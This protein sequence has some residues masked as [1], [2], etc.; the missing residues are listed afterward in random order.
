M[1]SP[2]LFC[3]GK[4]VIYNYFS[5]VIIRLH[6]H[7]I[8]ACI[9]RFLNNITVYALI[10]LCI[11]Y[12]LIIGYTSSW[13]FCSIHILCMV[14]STTVPLLH[15]CLNWYFCEYYVY[16]YCDIFCTLHYLLI[17]S[18]PYWVI[19]M[20]IFPDLLFH[21]FHLLWPASVIVY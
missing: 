2:S 18:D 3:L 4:F 13:Y 17:G 10:C 20:L 21:C 12:Y 8:C 7:Y 1:N 16:F 5:E 11:L 6:L 9:Y 14:Y 15:L 19:L